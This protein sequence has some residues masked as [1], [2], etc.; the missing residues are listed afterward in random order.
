MKLKTY[1]GVDIQVAS[2]GEFYCD[3][4]NNS[5]MYRDKVFNS[6]KVKSIEKAIDGFKAAPIS[7]AYLYTVVDY[8]C[9]I[10]KMP[11]TGKTGNRLFFA[12]GSD[13]SQSHYLRV[14]SID[15]LPSFEKAS[16]IAEEYER[17]S[18]EEKRIREEKAILVKA[19]KGH[20]SKW[21]SFK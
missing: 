2:D 9:L 10:K 20:S 8:S 6:G 17:L 18:A 3:P 16:I 11:I 19:F 12:D 21:K 4:V 14:A 13:S 1:K 7:G 15:G 5:S